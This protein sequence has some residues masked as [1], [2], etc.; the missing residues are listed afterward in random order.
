MRARRIAP[1][2]RRS[3]RSPLVAAAVAAALGCPVAGLASDA[4]ETTPKE[5][6]KVSVEADELAKYKV[7]ASSSAKYGAPVL[8][9]PQTLT[10]IPRSLIEERNATTL[11]DA[12][13]NTSGITFQAG[14]GGGGLPGDQNFTLR[15]F[16]ARSA[17]FVDGIRDPGSYARDT[18]FIE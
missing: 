9:T 2:A 11:R 7:D 14:E 18:F 4:E 6:P 10:I 5:M 16:S 12:L 17:L 13:R 8:D 15:G 1:E 3:G